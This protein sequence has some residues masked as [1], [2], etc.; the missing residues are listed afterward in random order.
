VYGVVGPGLIF[1]QHVFRRDKCVADDRNAAAKKFIATWAAKR[2]AGL[3]GDRCTPTLSYVDAPSGR[4]FAV[5]ISLNETLTYFPDMYGWADHWA[6]SAADPK[7]AG[8]P[9]EWDTRYDKKL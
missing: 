9:V 5:Y 6:W 7:L 3:E 2:N 8:A 4:V 1:T